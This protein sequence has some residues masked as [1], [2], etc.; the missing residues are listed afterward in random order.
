MKFTAV[1]FVCAA[2]VLPSGASAQTLEEML[3]PG[4]PAKMT[5]AFKA[6]CLDRLGS[7]EAQAAAA[8][9]QPWSFELRPGRIEGARV[10]V[11]WPL[12]LVLGTEGDQR[13][14]IVTS[15]LPDDTQL[16]GSR[17]EVGS[18]L[19]LGEGLMTKSGKRRAVLWKQDFDG[20]TGVVGWELFDGA[21]M[22]TAN[23]SVSTAK[24]E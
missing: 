14:C 24:A 15:S 23:L 11:A 12:Q 16:E 19:G 6:I 22:K 5:A 13:R 1:A 4:E 10:F 21:G 2:L 7:E 3:T 20:A 18:L 8:T 9:A 17:R